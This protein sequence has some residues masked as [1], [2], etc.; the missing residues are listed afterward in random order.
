MRQHLFVLA[1]VFVGLSV[2]SKLA[3]AEQCGTSEFGVQNVSIDQR[4]ETAG[5]ARELGTRA[6]AETAFGVV[7]KRLL[8]D[9]EIVAE[10]VARHDLDEFTDFVHISEENSL[11]GRYIALLDFCFDAARLRQSF[12]TSGLKWTELRS[13]PILVLPVWQGPEGARAWQKNNSWL[14]GWRDAVETTHG[15]VNFVLLE[16]TIVNERSLRAED[17]ARANQVTLSYAATLAGA[18][19]TMLVIARLDY[20]GATP[21]LTVDG[22]LFSR[23][24][25]LL[26]TLAKM[27]DMPVATNLAEQLGIA[28][29]KILGEMEASWYAANAISGNDTQRLTLVVPITSLAQWTS[30]LAVFDQIAVFNG[31]DIRKLDIGSG[32][33]TANV[34]GT[35]AAVENALLAHDLK[36]VTDVNGRMSIVSSKTR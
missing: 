31:Y 26:T 1:V 5:E 34:E 8:H 3:V 17:L 27:V 4:A 33:I 30:R 28:R 7:L 13:P 14:S 12:R 11:E 18:E 24:G 32:V 23:D 16:P 36:L 9:P 2:A 22:Q 10:F 15:L 35:I 19:Q 6:A 29:S 25:R 20:Q 21:V